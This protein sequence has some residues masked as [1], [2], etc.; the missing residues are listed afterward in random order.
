MRLGGSKAILV[1]DFTLSCRIKSGSA[2]SVLGRAIFARG[3]GGD[4]QLV[5]LR[6]ILPRAPTRGELRTYR[7]D[8]TAATKHDLSI[9]PIGVSVVM[10]K[11]RTH[12]KRGR[13]RTGFSK[14]R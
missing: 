10:R 14:T 12:Y 1:V 5:G 11:P 2:E 3:L 4:I 6:K 13:K 8:L 7:K 9:E